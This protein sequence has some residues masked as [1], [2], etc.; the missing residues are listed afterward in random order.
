MQA[1]VIVNC[2]L[3]F[4]AFI[5]AFDSH[6]YCLLGRHTLKS[7]YASSVYIQDLGLVITVPVDG[8]PATHDSI[9]SLWMRWCHKG[10]CDLGVSH[11]FKTHNLCSITLLDNQINW[12]CESP[13]DTHHHYLSVLF[14]RLL[15]YA[16]TSLA[17]HGF[18]LIAS[19]NLYGVSLL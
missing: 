8:P 14:A 11:G 1:K 5:L 13:L 15:S 10:P 7:L 18:L 12:T 9:S 17:R 16:W 3:F 19:G 2:L 4:K 6:C